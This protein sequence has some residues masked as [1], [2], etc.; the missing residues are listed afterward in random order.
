MPP[1]WCRVPTTFLQALESSFAQD[2]NGNGQIGVAPRVVE[3]NGATHLTEVGGSVYLFDYG[4]G[5][6]RL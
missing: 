6:V 4:P 2:L 3:A 1:A 5:W